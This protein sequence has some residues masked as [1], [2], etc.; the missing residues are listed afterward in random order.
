MEQPNKHNIASY[1]RRSLRGISF[2]T[3]A[4]ALATILYLG[5]WSL[6]HTQASPG[7]SGAHPAGNVHLDHFK[8]AVSPSTSSA[9]GW[10]SRA[11][12]RPAPNYK[13]KKADLVLTAT[14]LILIG[15][16]FTMALFKPYYVVDAAGRV[17]RI[18]A[19]DFAAFKDLIQQVEALP[20]KDWSVFQAQPDH[21]IDTFKTPAGGIIAHVNGWQRT[22]DVLETPTAGYTRLPAPL[23]SFIGLTRE[24]WEESTYWTPRDQALIDRILAF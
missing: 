23:Q 15:D 2:L 6:L 19:S 9:I 3:V 4:L 11:I 12:A 22:V 5:A 20:A 8:R 16:Y 21:P 10:H 17:L 24:S 7:N 1:R 13:P 18:S 14:Q